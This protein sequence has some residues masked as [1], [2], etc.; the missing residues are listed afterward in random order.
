M[1]TGINTPKNDEFYKHKIEL[2][3]RELKYL[4]T[5][6][7]PIYPILEQVEEIRKRFKCIDN[8]ISKLKT[9]QK[10]YIQNKEAVNSK[11]EF[12]QAIITDIWSPLTGDLRVLVNDGGYTFINVMDGI[13]S[14]A[15]K[16]SKI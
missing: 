16:S 3:Y 12:I 9:G 11:E 4:F 1:K 13:Y 2:E 7:N 14:S 8:T 5:H 10:I 6:Y 15:N